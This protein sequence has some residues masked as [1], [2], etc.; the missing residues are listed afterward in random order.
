LRELYD[1][2]LKHEKS[3]I[4]FPITNS[5]FTYED[6]IA[7]PDIPWEYEHFGENASLTFDFILENPTIC[8]GVEYLGNVSVNKFDAEKAAYLERRRREYMAAY[9]I[10]QWWLRT[11]SDPRNVVCIRRLERDFAKFFPEQ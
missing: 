10:Q 4:Y 3:L 2:K 5:A 6:I 9:Q 8:D 1:T 11:T 7:N